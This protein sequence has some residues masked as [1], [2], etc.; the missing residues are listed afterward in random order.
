MKKVITGL[1]SCIIFLS[2]HTTKAQDSDA[3]TKQ[4][5]IDTSFLLKV[6]GVEQY[7]EIKGASRANP[8]LLFIH[9]GPEWPATPMI[10][11]YNQDLTQNFVLV[12]WD[13][14]NCGKSKTDNLA[15][16]TP[17]LYVEDAHQVTH[18]LKKEFHVSKIFVACH[19]WG[20][21]IGVNL[22]LKY[23]EDYTAYIGMGQFVNPNKSEAL[24]RR[25]VTEQAKLS[26][27]TV[28]LNALNTI[29]FSEEYGYK[30]GFDDLIK[31]SM[32]AN[33]YFRSA[34]VADLPD[35]TQ[36]YSDY[37]KLDWMTPVMI[38][39]KTLFN[40]M[41][42][43]NI[44]FSPFKEFKVP[45]YFFI[46]RYD[47]TTS[48]LVAEEYFRTIKAPKKALFWFEHSG[49]SPNWEESTLFYQRVL[50]VAAENKTNALSADINVKMN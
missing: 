32:M 42:A 1:L 17:D 18:Y 19:S 39:G 4:K 13:Q 45:V 24:A 37:S 40:Y 50:Q 30:N 47:H 49:H 6:N 33:K 21:I 3:K 11:K 35:P 31:F 12:S 29:P 20:T 25:F 5:P 41:N 38:Y 7:L 44:D 48:A 15:K 8:V 28:T 27:D 46:G 9:G 26:K 14:R 22:V 16:L 34:E 36:L 23:P 10:R 2:H 43:M